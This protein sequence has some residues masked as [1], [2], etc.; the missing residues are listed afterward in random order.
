MAILE[1]T[2]FSSLKEENEKLK[3]EVIQLRNYVKV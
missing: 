1:K 2:E 3:V